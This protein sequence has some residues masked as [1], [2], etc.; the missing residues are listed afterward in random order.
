MTLD[1]GERAVVDAA[2]LQPLI[3]ALR[4][5]GYRVVGPTVDQGAIVLAELTR[6]DALPRGLRQDKAGGRE[7]LRDGGDG[8]YFAH[9]V[10]PQAPKQYLH[11][12]ERRICRIER[13]GDDLAMIAEPDDPPATALLGM[14]ACDLAGMAVLDGVL[15][16]DRYC[17]PAYAA[18]RDNLIVIAVNCGEAGGTCFCASM[19]TGPRASHGFDLALTELIADARHD[20]LA[21]V[22][23]ETG[24]ALL[25]D[26][27]NRP[28]TDADIAA[29]E[30]ASRTAEAG[31]GRHLETDGLKDLLQANRAHPRWDDV[32]GRCLTC[33]NCTMVCPT[34]FCTS[35][36]D[37]ASLD[38]AS[39]ERW[40]H[41]ESCFTLAFSFIHGGS[42]RASAR[43][44]YRQWITHKL[45]DWH[46]QFGTSGC[47]GCGRCI[48]WCPVGIDITE[49]AAAIR[50][51]P[52]GGDAT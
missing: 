41:W 47:V 17:D 4:G 43:S 28:P 35:V 52:N 36:T 1:P 49:E 19:G 48:A 23:S 6:A 51:D 14:R 40:Q 30:A 46:D 20:F 8:A 50:A 37:T 15:R 42:V 34:C 18:R 29:A 45:A 3:D 39:A 44:R 22:G 27:A 38:G 16:D 33:A 12:P 25:A 32:A 11:P 13:N 31:M 24:A 21:E 5:R 26:L 9:T 7:R 10:G 2:Q